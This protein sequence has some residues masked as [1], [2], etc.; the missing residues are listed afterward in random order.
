MA[1]ADALAAVSI[2]EMTE[3]EARM[4]TLN[5]DIA[6]YAPQNSEADAQAAVIAALSILRLQWGAFYPSWRAWRDDHLTSFQRI[7]GTTG[8]QFG[9]FKVRYN[10]YRDK[11]IQLGGTTTAQATSTDAPKPSDSLLDTGIKVLAFGAAC[12]LGW[13]IF[14]PKDPPNV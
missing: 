2:E 13:K 11:L 6:A 4:A 8:I 1:S 9:Q 5:S 7:G 14:G 12:F 10:G 3:F